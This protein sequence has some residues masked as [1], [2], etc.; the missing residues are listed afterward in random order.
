MGGLVAADLAIEMHTEATKHTLPSE[1]ARPWP[2]V[3]GIL[4]FDTPYLGVHPQVFARNIWEHGNQAYNTYRSISTAASGLGKWGAM[5][6]TAAVASGSAAAA[7]M[8]RGQLSTGLTWAQDHLN[9]VSILFKG[10]ELST[11][12]NALCQL[13]H[14]QFVC[15]YTT[16]STSPPNTT[17]LVPDRT[18]CV[19]PDQPEIRSHFHSQ[20]NHLAQDE[21]QA[22]I[23]MFSPKSNS[24]YYPMADKVSPLI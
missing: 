14:L 5:A 22:H 13:S 4:A 23:G 11:R 9:F 24:D 2:V 10:S 3:A 16:L 21:I 18:F 20:V 1:I 17:S 6:V 15:I 8:N 7:I 12:L 19:L